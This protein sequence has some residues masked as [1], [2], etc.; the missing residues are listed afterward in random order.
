MTLRPRFALPLLG[1]LLAALAAPMG[2]ADDPRSTKLLH[3]SYDPT[4]EL[5]R[6]VNAAFAKSAAAR[7]FGRV[8]VEQSHG[9][10]GTQAR[11][12]IDG[13]PADVVSLAL[14]S[15][16]DALVKAKLVRADWRAA[17]PHGS[18]PFTSTIVFLVRK[19]NPRKIREWGDLVRPGVSVVTPNPKTSGGARWAY[20]AA[21][22]QELKR[23]KGDA[24]AARAF[25]EK[26]YRNVPV[27]DTGARG[28][29]NTFVRRGIGDVLLSW[30]NEARL[31]MADP[32]SRGVE[33]VVPAVSI[34]AEPPVAVVDAQAR[35]HGTLAAARAYM[36]FLF[37]PEAQELAARNHYRPVDAAVLA[38]HPEFARLDLFTVDELFGGW[39]KAQATHFAEGGVF[40]QAMGIR[41]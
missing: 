5:F 34:R 10:S 38:R 11:A 32:A 21:W 9:S 7:P 14:A 24:A 33:M 29:T 3:V 36:E 6:G 28:S 1:T 19:G 40:D 4:R 20:L 13:L 16:V 39:E 30:E 26:L 22:G 31:A 8:A 37:T 27:L 23:T 17:L 15:D 41:R 18:V 2:A 25:V 35:R 12:V